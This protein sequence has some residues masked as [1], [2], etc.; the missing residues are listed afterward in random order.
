MSDLQGQLIEVVQD[1]LAIE[2]NT[3]VKPNMTATR[4]RNV[5]HTLLDIISEYD[6]ELARLDHLQRTLL[7]D[8]AEQPFQKLSTTQHLDLDI[9]VESLSSR[10][11]K[12]CKT[13]ALLPHNTGAEGFGDSERY[14]LIRIRDNCD[15]ILGI[16]DALKAREKEASGK[17]KE[18]GRSILKGVCRKNA[19]TTNIPLHT[20]ERLQL[21]KIWEIGTEEVKMQTVIQL[22]GDVFTRIQREL[23]EGQSAYPKVVELHNQGVSLAVGYW[24]KLSELVL[25]FFNSLIGIRK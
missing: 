13:A 24:Q 7:G 5:A 23:A 6:A 17:G 2:V 21:R 12:L 9:E 19:T 1:L 20:G 18:S 4:M 14:L 15:T 25:S 8:P 22:S 16:F 3:I 11:R 10:A